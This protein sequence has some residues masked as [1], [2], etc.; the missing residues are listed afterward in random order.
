MKPGVLRDLGVG[1]F[2]LPGLNEGRGDFQRSG[3]ILAGRTYHVQQ[4][5][6]GRSLE[7]GDCDNYKRLAGVRQRRIGC[8]D[9]WSGR[10]FLA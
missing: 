1:V 3:A 8:A 5:R 7:D 4:A 2:A 9:G 6:H 10:R